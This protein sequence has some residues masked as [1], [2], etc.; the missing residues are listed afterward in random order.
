MGSEET[1]VCQVR[2]DVEVDFSGGWNFYPS[3]GSDMVANVQANHS[4]ITT[5]TDLLTFK[6]ILPEDE[7]LYAC[8]AKEEMLGRMMRPQRT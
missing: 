4:R 1:L 2:Q 8:V 7:G 6:N 3:N 5:D